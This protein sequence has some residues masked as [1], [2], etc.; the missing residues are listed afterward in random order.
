M[1]S[2][3]IKFRG[4]SPKLKNWVYGSLI[5]DT[6]NGV[7]DI[8][9]FDFTGEHSFEVEPKS[10]GQFTGLK[11]NL[12]ESDIIDVCIFLVSP[13]NPDNDQHFR[14]EVIFQNGSWQFK[15]HNYLRF[16]DN[17]SEW[18]NLKPHYLPFD[19]VELDD[20][21]TF[22]VELY[23]FMCMSGNMGEWLDDNINI[24]GNIFEHSHLLTVK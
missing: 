22:M 5:H 3:E 17:K 20:D 6:E 13:S 11:E 14:G 16:N 23:S 8:E 9:W 21:G 7:Y 19:D 24:V 10:V 4:Y 15:I 12:F 2:R 18:V 1:E